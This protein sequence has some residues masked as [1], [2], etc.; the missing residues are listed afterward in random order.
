MQTKE[1]QD[2]KIVIATLEPDGKYRYVLNR[3]LSIKR[4]QRIIQ[5][6]KGEELLERISYDTKLIIASTELN[7]GSL[8]IEKVIEEL[9]KKG[10]KDHIIL[11][12]LFQ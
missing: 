4:V 10:F 2:K 5:C 3:V 1:A 6:E 7:R 9:R 12:L 8:P 11:L